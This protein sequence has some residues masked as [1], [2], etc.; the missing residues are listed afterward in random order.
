MN[1]RSLRFILFLIVLILCLM[2]RP[3]LTDAQ[4]KKPLSQEAPSST[5]DSNVSITRH[6]IKLKGQVIPYTAMAGPLTLKTEEGTPKANVFFVAYFRDDIKDSAERPLIFC[7]NGGPGSSTVWLHLGAFAPKKVF[8]D[9]EGFP[10]QPFRLVDNPYT[11]ID[12]ADVV[13]IDA[14]ST[15]FSRPAPGQDPKQFHGVQEDI[16]AVGDFIRLFVTRTN[17]W[18]SPKFILGESYG[19]TRAAGLAGYLQGRS[20]GMALNGIILVS[21]VLEFQ[22]LEFSPGNDLPYVLFLPAYA[23]TAW[24]HKKLPPDLLA[25]PLAEVLKEAEEFAV[26]EYSRFLMLGNRSSSE[27]RKA[28][29]EKLARLTGLSS[30][31][32]EQANLRVSAQRFFKA[33]RRDEGLTVGRLDSR[34]TGRDADAAGE[35][36]ESDPSSTAIMGPFSALANHYLRVDLKYKND[37]NYAIYGN[38]QPWRWIYSEQQRSPQIN[39]AETLRQAMSENRFLKVFV[40]RG[41][42]DLATPYFAIDHTMAHIG[43]NGE[44]KDRVKYGSYEAGHMMYI[45]RESHARLEKDLKDFIKWAGFPPLVSPV[46]K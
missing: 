40:V 13:F 25:K 21:P 26:N 17:R 35:R 1:K 5:I 41:L 44:F 8:F 33:L 4:D 9:D 38:V 10:V 16:A 3:E 42:Y 24:Y 45:H 22:T 11:L 18:L 32:L 28:C 37:I 39:M 14:I 2:F 20:I 46:V 7:F 36:P 31:Y 19:T 43:L 23:A 6:T 12:V 29:L 15:G 30:S 27:M 34:F